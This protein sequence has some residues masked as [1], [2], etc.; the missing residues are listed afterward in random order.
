[1]RATGLAAGAA[2]ALLGLSACHPRPAAVPKES[3]AISAEPVT[4]TAAD[5][6]K[7]FG[8]HTSVEKPKALI[9]LFHQAGSGKDEYAT[10]APRLATWGYSSLRIDQ[11]AGGDL[12]G[13]NATV[14]ALGRSTSYYQAK[15]DLVAALAWAKDRKLPVI[16]WGSSYSA[17]LV[18]LLAADYPDQVKAVMAFS[19]GEYFDN[20]TMVRTAAANV[21]APVFAT[22][23]QDGREIDAVR[24]ILAAVPGQKEQ[25]VPKQGGAH[26]SSTLLRAKNPEGAEPA[27]TAVIAFL[28]KVAP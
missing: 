8:V 12:F 19:P 15:P 7:V 10:I 24:D 13:G 3:R 4:L 9:L 27:W 25:F 6:V 14:K 28:Q 17:S 22:S 18:F 11:R 1:M 16:L 23:A 21:K 20:K 2:L 26:G 5:G